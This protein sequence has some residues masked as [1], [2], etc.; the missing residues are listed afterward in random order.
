[1]GLPGRLRLEAPLRTPATPRSTPP[2]LGHRGLPAC[3]EE[4]GRRLGSGAPR[5]RRPRSAE[6][7]TRPPSRAL[8][9]ERA[10]GR[11][12]GWRAKSWRGRL[13]ALPVGGGP[14]PGAEVSPR[15][16]PIRS[17]SPAGL[18]RTRVRGF[19]APGNAC[20]AATARTLPGHARRARGRHQ[21][22]GRALA[23]RPGRAGFGPRPAA[24]GAA[25]TESQ[26]PH[27]E[28]RGNRPR[29]REGRARSPCVREAGTKGGG[30]QGWCQ[31]PTRA[32]EDSAGSLAH[33]K[34]NSWRRCCHRS[35]IL[36]W[37]PS[38]SSPPPPPPRQGSLWGGCQ[39]H[40]DWKASVGRRDRPQ[41]RNWEGGRE[42]EKIQS[43]A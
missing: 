32:P 42:E 16:L 34:G 12:R 8:G 11:S 6:Q 28:K 1:M 15:S 18:T 27:L 29:A 41:S 4:A 2:A 23:T 31:G 39:S 40:L 9:R 13:S 3:G 17:L 37:I 25:L 5:P 24:S 20:G 22:T 33:C 7:P 10:K 43:G 14:S 38:L 19:A 30:G 26:E 21:L 35:W 36:I